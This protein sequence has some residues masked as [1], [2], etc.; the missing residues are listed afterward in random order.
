MPGEKVKVGDYNL[1]S[2]TGIQDQVGYSRGAV[3]R[4][5]PQQKASNLDS[6]QGYVDSAVKKYENASKDLLNSVITYE[7][8]GM[9]NAVSVTGALGP[10]QITSGNYNAGDGFNPFDPEAAIDHGTGISSSCIKKFGVT[11]KV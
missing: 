2:V 4:L 5:Y 3:G 7:S 11:K 9:I 6:L 1:P 8:G 10:M